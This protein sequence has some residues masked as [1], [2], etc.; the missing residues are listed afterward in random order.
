MGRADRV[1]DFVQNLTITSGSDA[2]KPFIL[3]PWQRE[4]IEAVYDP[5]DDDGLRQCETALLTMPRKNGKTTLI[6]ALALCH[7]CG[8]ERVERG[9][10]YSAAADRNQASL[11]YEEI[12]A[13]VRAD[14]ELSSIL[15][16]LDGTKRIVFYPNGSFFA[17]ISSESRT[18][19]GFNASFIAYDEL[20][21]APNRKLFDVLTTSTSARA[22]PLTMVISTQSPDPHHV[23]SELVDYGER[24][25]AG[26]IDDPSFVS[27]IYRADDDDDI[28]DEAVWHKANPALADFRSLRELRRFAEKAKRIPAREAAFRSLYLNQRIAKEGKL[29]NPIDWM[30]N[31]GSVDLDALVGRECYAGLD[32]SERRDLTALVLVFPDGEDSFDV[33]SW[34]W[35]PETDLKERADEDRQPYDQWNLQG[36]LETTPGRMI[37]YDFVVARLAEIHEQ[38]RIKAIAYDKWNM[39][40][41]MQALD[42]IG[43]ELPLV[44][45][46]QGFYSMTPAVGVLERCV[47]NGQLRTN[48]QPVLTMCV[49][50]TVVEI[51]AAENRKLAKNKSTGRIDGA[52]ALAMA[53]RTATEHLTEPDKRISIPAD[54][55]VTVF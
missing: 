16:L 6:A 2:G 55:Q 53:L 18:K 10:C 54:Y 37:N 46:R 26:A 9:Q 12:A 29:I 15:H 5:V 27:R 32:L 52:V 22:E 21:Q 25:L 28:W 3:R 34:F 38:F 1:I 50:N 17:S 14:A 11:I 8:P 36:Y 23:M 40:R 49:L 19:H 7:L 20:A 35:L 31:T 39:P 42:Q 24:V 43:L 41:M 13:F 48:G 33:L 44:E 45:F 51:D 30:K 4:F 47:L